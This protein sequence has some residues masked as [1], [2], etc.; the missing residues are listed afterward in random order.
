GMNPLRVTC[1]RFIN[2]RKSFIINSD[3]DETIPIPAR[4]ALRLSFSYS[5]GII[6]TLFV[7][8]YLTL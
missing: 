7:S 1:G 2:S 8:L 5:C 6:N 3:I 4:I